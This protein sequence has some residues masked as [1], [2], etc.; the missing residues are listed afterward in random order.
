MLEWCVEFIVL[1]SFFKHICIFAL[2]TISVSMQLTIELCNV[3]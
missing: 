3:F 1:F 2:V